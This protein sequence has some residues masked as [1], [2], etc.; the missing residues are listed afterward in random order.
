MIILSCTVR[1]EIGFVAGVSSD[2]CL[3]VSEKIEPVYLISSRIWRNS[4]Y[5]IEGE[6]VVRALTLY[7]RKKIVNAL[8]LPCAGTL[9]FIC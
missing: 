9:A 7:F 4:G 1:P 2:L 6:F 5:C 8:F 3:S